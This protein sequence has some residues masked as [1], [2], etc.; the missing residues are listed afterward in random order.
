MGVGG[1]IHLMWVL[2]NFFIIIVCDDV[3]RRIPITI[4]L[5]VCIKQ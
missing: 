2:E 3:N 1:Y 4:I 5:S